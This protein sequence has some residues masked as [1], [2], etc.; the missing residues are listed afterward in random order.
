MRRVIYAIALIALCSC[1]CSRGP[2][3]TP[4]S[5]RLS[6]EI[7]GTEGVD[8]VGYYIGGDGKSC[9]I[10]GTTPWKMNNSALS[11]NGQ[12]GT[13][14][15]A[16]LKIQRAPKA[17]SGVVR[18]ALSENGKLVFH[19]ELPDDKKELVYENK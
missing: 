11:L 8:F 7:A 18:V 17:K 6:L 2:T 9:D 12:E 14:S 16:Y 15:V 3:T 4:G 5:F 1:G 13:K 10:S 19:G